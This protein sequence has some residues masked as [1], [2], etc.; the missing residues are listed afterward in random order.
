MMRLPVLLVL[1]GSAALL[2]ALLPGRAAAATREL[3]NT[4]R[5]GN[6]ADVPTP[7]GY[8]IPPEGEPYREIIETA[9]RRYNLPSGLLARLLWKESRFRPDA[10][11]ASSGAQGIAQ[12]VPRWHPGVDPFDP[13]E[14]IPYAAGY[15]R[16]NFN[17]FGSWDKA[18]AAYNWGPTNVAGAVAR[19]DNAWTD[20]LP[21]ETRDYVTDITGAVSTVPTVR[22]V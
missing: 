11:N 19:L 17:R 3:V 13:R 16:E 20:A 5:R 2:A 1:G 14:A 21:R 12:I 7:P 8:E 22:L 15:L 4:M 18:L 6:I 10:V 9:E